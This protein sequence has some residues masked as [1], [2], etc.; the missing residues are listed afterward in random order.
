MQ[1]Q[2]CL[3]I[4]L[5]GEQNSQPFLELMNHDKEL[6]LVDGTAFLFRAH[7]AQGGMPLAT[8]DGRV[9]QAIY[10]MINMLRSLIREFQPTHIAIVMDAPGGNFRHELYEPYK[11]NRPPMPE[12]LRDQLEYIR[13]IIPAMGLKLVCVPGVEA[14]DVIGTF[15]VMG[16]DRGYR[17]VIVSS[18][19][20]LAQLVNERVSM[21]DTMKRTWLGPQGVVDRFGVPP[22]RIVDYLT[23][24]GDT[25]DNI[26]GVPKVG[27]KTACKWISQYGNLAGI[28]ENADKIPG[29]IGEN[30]R[31]SLDL[32]PLYKELVTVRC[33]VE[34]GIEPEDLKPGDPDHDQ[35]REYFVD[36]EFRSWL[37]ELDPG[38]G[39]AASNHAGTPDESVRYEAILDEQALQQWITKLEASRV[40]SIDTET[41]SINPRTASLVGL[42]FSVEPGEAAYLPLGHT[43]LGFP[44]QLPMAE[45]LEKLR[46]VLEDPA[47]PKTGQNLKYDIVV[48]RRH[49]IS[50]AGITHDTMLLSYVLDP[51]SSR[52]DMDSLAGRHL[53][54]QTTRFTDIA[55][56]GRNQL[57]F[58]Q[59][60]L[61]QAAPY[62]AED[63]DIT[64]QLHHLLSGQL[65]RDEKLSR[66]FTELELPLMHALVR[67]ESHG[68]RID[69]SLLGEQSAEIAAQLAVLEKRAHDE[70][71]ESFNI[72]SPKQIQEIL[73]GKM[74]L[75]PLK[76]TPGGQPSTSESVLQ[77]L[78]VNH[79]LPR[80]I[81]EHRGLAKLKNTYTD[82][83]PELINPHTRR[84]HTSYHQ[85]VAS[86][87]RLSSSD[88][89]LQNIPVRT[90]EGRRIRE[91]F[92]AEPGNLL[93]AADYSQIELRIMAH[94]SCDAGLLD[95]FNNG[96]DV[97]SAT[98]AEVFGIPA[99]QVD[100]EQRRRAKAINFG[101]IYGMS[102][103]GLARQLKIQQSEAKHYIDTYFAHYPGVREY[104]ES[105]KRRAR[106][107]GYVET[108]YGRRLRL[109]DIQSRN[110]VLRQYSERIAI[111]APIQGTA[112]DIIK[113]AMIDLDDRLIRTG[114]ASR[115]IMQVHDELVLEVPEAQIDAISEMTRQSMSEANLAGMAGLD[116]PLVV[117]IGQ[118]R[119]WGEAH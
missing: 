101:L 119:N 95:A 60:D 99:E 85:A 70:A 86:T 17:T 25:S 49:G 67:T 29:K 45:T 10:G 1:S 14:D 100:P 11:A 59:I 114:S 104:M 74:G 112:A 54:R 22:E 19:K 113:L 48:L 91:A 77:D 41:T 5:D 98:A 87:G 21:H 90:Q 65:S 44:E 40:F 88:P 4:R 55:G 31:S 38:A 58:D 62:A 24:A 16:T 33:D 94:L 106:E 56:T 93:L 78:A 107:C 32:L 23:L 26:P 3:P 89:N 75:A 79:E 52:H 57:S 115:I 111:N 97:H 66:I 68:V 72:G 15:S 76:K 71:G 34:T 39:M 43:C 51:G 6:I 50:L 13:K 73:F 116:V 42:S 118:G 2:D 109:P 37:A 80:I 28:I 63:A 35:L 92:I 117:D 83:L 108:L 61:E 20:D 12:D 53:D 84:I 69:A 102:A 9:T 110:A 81:L 46:P 105:A 36:L 82:K 7:H 30:L 47:R 96:V 103:F 8:S 27:S 18:D 64:L